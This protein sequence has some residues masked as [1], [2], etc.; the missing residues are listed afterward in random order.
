MINGLKQLVLVWL[1]TAVVV[2]F[3]PNVIT[4]IQ[5]DGFQT[6]L[7]VSAFNGLINITL[8]PILNL[9]FLPLRFLTFG[10][11][12]IIIN[13]VCLGLIDNML[14]GFHMIT[15]WDALWLSIALAISGT[16]SKW[17]LDK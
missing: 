11:F 17:I 5:L 10:L 1:I 16:L 3:S 9:V 4:G 14:I 2:Y 12:S 15:F 8:K 6:A 13:W 7:L